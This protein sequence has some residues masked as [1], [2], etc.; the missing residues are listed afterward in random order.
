MFS[1]MGFIFESVNT[2]DDAMR[3]FGV[4]EFPKT[5]SELNQIYK[6][7]SVQYHPD[8]GGFLPDGI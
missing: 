4:N 2:L 8:L 6:K 1:F 5:K 3:I 7:L